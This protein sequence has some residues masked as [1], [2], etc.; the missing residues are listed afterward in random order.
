MNHGGGCKFAARGL[1]VRMHER[2]CEFRLVR[3][4][5]HRCPR[6]VQFKNLVD[7]LMESRLDKEIRDEIQ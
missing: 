7:H 4:P 3:C 1:E 6:M 2:A 5:D